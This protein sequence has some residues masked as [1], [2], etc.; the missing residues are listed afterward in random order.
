[1]DYLGGPSHAFRLH[2]GFDGGRPQ[3]IDAGHGIA[4]MEGAD[5]RT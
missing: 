3:G 4:E 1:V 5:S 2:G